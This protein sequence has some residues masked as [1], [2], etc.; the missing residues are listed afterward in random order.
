MDIRENNGV[1]AAAER[2]VL[3]WLAR[4]IPRRVNP[5]HLTALAA[6]GM[7][8]CAAGFIAG[9]AERRAL[10]VVVAGLVINWFGDSL[11]G[12]LARVRDCQRPRY[13]YYVDH[14]L[15]AA[16]ILVLFAGLAISGFMTPIVAAALL[17]AYYLVSIEVYLATHA[18]GRF[19]MS[20]WMMGPTELRIVL[21]IGA[22]A[23][24]RDPSVTLAGDPYLLFDVGG[25]IGAAGLLA[26][27][28]VSAI[29]NTRA[30]FRQEPRIRV[31]EPEPEP[32]YPKYP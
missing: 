16:G 3:L 22:L 13:G 18:L 19:R 8:L 1:L 10:L 27:A 30:L 7:A 14:V 23:L 11:D 5:D 15:D 2:R 4:R 29:S 12:T 6:A 17:I 20:F 26:T 31:A 32:K 9:A 21:A 24:M 28:V 25:A